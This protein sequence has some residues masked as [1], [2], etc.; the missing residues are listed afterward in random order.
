MEAPLRW[1]LLWRDGLAKQI[2]GFTLLGLSALVLLFSMRKRLRW[3]KLG[4]FRGWRLV[5]IGI[6]LTAVAVLVLHTGLRLGHNLNAWLMLAFSALLITGAV[7]GLSIA[8]QHRWT[9][10][11]ARRLRKAALWGHVLTFWPLP[12]LLGFHVLKTYWF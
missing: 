1:D 6:S 8:L 12:A 2:S 9:P 5:H 3:F 7:G 11:S 4:T 10:A